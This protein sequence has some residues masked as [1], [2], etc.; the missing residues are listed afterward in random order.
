MKFRKKSLDRIGYYLAILS[1]TIFL[2]VA[3]NYDGWIAISAFS[4]ASM[5]GLYIFSSSC[6]NC[7][8]GIFLSANS[9]KSKG[10][11]S[12][13]VPDSCPSCHQARW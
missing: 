4:V 11:R 9:L 10:V 7:G 2:T 6:E 5:V 12:I 8:E 13:F 1:G 3:M